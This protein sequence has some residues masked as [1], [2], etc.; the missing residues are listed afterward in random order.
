MPSFRNGYYCSVITVVVWISHLPCVRCFIFDIVY[1]LTHKLRWRFSQIAQSVRIDIP[2]SIIG[3]PTLTPCKWTHSPIIG[4]FTT[5]PRGSN[6]IMTTSRNRF[7]LR[8][9]WVGIW[10]GL[11]NLGSPSRNLTWA[12]YEPLLWSGVQD[13]MKN[14]T[15]MGRLRFKNTS[16]L[17]SFAWQYACFIRIY[18]CHVSL[19]AFQH[20]IS[21]KFH[22]RH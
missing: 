4:D 5:P 14:I 16:S 22:L 15:T 7:S 8:S 3:G 10:A 12:N 21:C 20:I 9:S 13:H 2:S 1:I 6:L 11:L 18:I 19:C 17:L